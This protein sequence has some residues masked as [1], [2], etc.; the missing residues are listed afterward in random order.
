MQ[1]SVTGSSSPA[2]SEVESC[3]HRHRRRRPRRAPTHQHCNPLLAASPQ[4][5]AAGPPSPFTLTE[6]KGDTLMTLSRDYKGEKV[7]VE[8]M[9]N[10]QVGAGCCRLW[11]L[12]GVSIVGAGWCFQFRT[13]DTWWFEVSPGAGCC[14]LWAGERW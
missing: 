1:S 5:L 3:R 13:G 14:Q 4:E 2:A 11:V 9:G 6:S 12:A 10:D 8:L 7:T